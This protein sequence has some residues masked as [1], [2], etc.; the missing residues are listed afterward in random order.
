MRTLALALVGSAIVVACGGTT[1]S[2]NLFADGGGDDSGNKSDGSNTGDSGSVKDS[3]TLP[4]GAPDC[5][6]LAAALAALRQK[7]NACTNGGVQAACHQTI[8]DFC[9]P[10]TVTSPD[11]AESKAFET[12]RDNFK[13]LCG[14]PTCPGLPCSPAPTNVCGTN[15]QCG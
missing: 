14:P 15:G 7:A 5:N 1:D 8:S 2:T 6:A 13:N 11:S 9:C 3:A 12:A 4:D 10:L